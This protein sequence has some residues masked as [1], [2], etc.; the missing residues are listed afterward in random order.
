MDEVWDFEFT[1]KKALDGNIEEELSACGDD[2]FTTLYQ[3]ILAHASVQR[4]SI[5]GDGAQV[6]VI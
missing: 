6:K 1:E 2:A 3:C 5:G 4:Q